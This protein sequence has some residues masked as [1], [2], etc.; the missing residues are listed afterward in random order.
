[1]NGNYWARILSER[2]SRRRAI[3]GTATIGA[4]AA[5]L[6]ACGGDSA[7]DE[8]VDKS[9]L[10]TAREDETNKGV[11]GGVWANNY[12]N[13]FEGIDPNT[14]FNAAAFAL[15]TPVYSTLVKYGKSVG[16]LPGPETISGDAAESWEISP[17]GLQ[18]TYKMRPNHTYD[19]RPPTNGRA[20]TTADVKFSWERTTALSPTAAD[21]LR[22]K[23]PTGPID[24]LA[25][26]DD[27]TVVIK[28]A[29]PY[30]P[31]NEMMAYWYLHIAPQ[32]ADGKFDPR[33]EAR[34]SGPY[35]LDK[36]QPS[37][38][39]TYKRNPNWYV[40]NRPFLDGIIHYKIPEQATADA[41][42]EAKAIWATTTTQ[43]ET[44]LRMKKDHPE[45]VMRQ[46][47]K[48]AAPGGYPLLFGKRFQK[49][50]RLR[51]AVS[52]LFDRDSLLNGAA[53]FS[54]DIWQKAGLDVE[55]FWD[56][57]LSSNAVAWLDPRTKELG[58]GA[59]WFQFNPTEAKK[60]MSA[61][62][63]KGEAIDFVYRANFGPAGVPDILSA[64]IEEGGFKL[65]RKAV[66]V[67]DWRNLKDSYGADFDDMF[68]STANSYNDDGYL[69]TKYTSGGKDRV[70]PA[71]LP[72]VAPQVIKARSERDPKKRVELLKQVQK[73]LANLM[74]D[75]PV[76][77]TVPTLGYSLRW[78]WFRNDVFS[79]PGFNL[80]AS[81]AR[82]YTDYWYDKSKQT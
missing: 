66:P 73:D 9:G 50:V 11:A 62:G 34:G 3:A 82:P 79:V 36:W 38:S 21:I 12:G 25:T 80:N 64:M 52:M 20:M 1:M 32:E 19:Q 8:P 60:L 54:V 26:P 22:S 30:G 4:A 71:D 45:L 28:L 39:F 10:L 40:K 23:S 16:E 15:I 37:I 6:A 33:N 76:V 53:A 2:T 56:G 58:D 69:G 59:Q 41:Q 75:L 61:A 81:T 18:V 46:G 44:M 65:N 17:D 24:S 48:A 47:V 5:F 68:W 49:E 51:R 72:E 35:M 78:P 14:N 63:Y 42:F 57:H 7:S 29:E 27:K 70:T 13:N 77:S 31:I 55:T 43:A 74:P 67:T